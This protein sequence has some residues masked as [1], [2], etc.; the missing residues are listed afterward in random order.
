M[1][2]NKQI[3]NQPQQ[4]PWVENEITNVQDL[5]PINAEAMNVSSDTMAFTPCAEQNE[6]VQDDFSDP[7]P[8][9]NM[10]I[11]ATLGLDEDFSVDSTITQET[12]YQE[13]NG[14][15]EEFHA[16]FHSTPEQE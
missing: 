11:F 2:E 3:P 13:A 8:E 10:D 6:S 5:D 15:S 9:F 12:V 7:E 16:M 14:D 1:D 4:T